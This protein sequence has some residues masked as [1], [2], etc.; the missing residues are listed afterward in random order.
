MKKEFIM[1][2]KT[3]SGTNEV[4]NF[5][6]LKKGY[7][8]RLIEFELFPSASIGAGNGY[9]LAA[10]L[11]AAKTYEDPGN[12]NFVNEGLIATA[13]LFG[14][15]DITGPY[16]TSVI[17]DLFVITQDLIIAVVDTVSGA[18]MDVNWQCKFKSEKM[19]GPEEAAT[20]YRQFTIFDG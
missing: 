15:A 10:S 8:Y 16:H 18:P 11:T 3:A 6:G 7:G 9:E 4:L 1:R 12:P 19:S 2:G 13:I 17:N 14:R 5:S 20:N